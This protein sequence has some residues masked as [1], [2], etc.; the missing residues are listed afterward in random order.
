[1]QLKLL[2]VE[3]HRTIAMV[4]LTQSFQMGFV[5]KSSKIFPDYKSQHQKG[6]NTRILRYKFSFLLISLGK[7][8]ENKMQM[9]FYGWKK[10][11]KY[12]Q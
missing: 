5:Q 10:L 6:F 7:Y 12:L 1:V 3:P 11:Q 8:C 9:L 2:C 4:E